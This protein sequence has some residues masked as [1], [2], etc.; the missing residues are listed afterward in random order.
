[1][2]IFNSSNIDLKDDNFE[3]IIFTENTEYNNKCDKIYSDK[4][5]ELEN[6]K[7]EEI[8]EYTNKNDKIEYFSNSIGCPI[9]YG[10][11]LLIYNNNDTKVLSKSDGELSWG[12][13]LKY[14]KYYQFTP[15]NLNNISK[16]IKYGDNIEIEEHK[17]ISSIVSSSYYLYNSGSNEL[18][19]WNTNINAS[20]SSNLKLPY[21]FTVMACVYQTQR[22]RDWVRVIGKGNSRNRNYGI[23]IRSDG[24]TLAQI[25]GPRGGSVWPGPV[26]PLNKWT[27]LAITFKRNNKLKF[28]FNG[29]L[30]R[31]VNTS[32]TPR[33]DNE[34]LTLG[35][36]TFHTKLYGK[37]K[38]AIV[39]NK[40]ISDDKIREFNKAS[41]ISS[42]IA[43]SII[44]R[45][46]REYS[47]YN[48]NMSVSSSSKLKLRERFTVMAWVYQTQRSRDWVRVI[49]KG[50]HR[51]RNYGIWI[52]PNG[53]SL[54]QIYGISNP[55]I[56]AGPVVPLNTW[57]HLATTFRKDGQHKFYF[58]GKL[59]RSSN[60][61][62]TPRTDNE[63][64]KLGGANFHGKFYGKI[65][66][67]FV[68][69][70]AL[71]ENQIQIFSR[72]P[73]DKLES[74]VEDMKIMPGSGNY[75]SKGHEVNYGENIVIETKKKNI[76]AVPKKPIGQRCSIKIPKMIESNDY[77][78]KQIKVRCDDK[79]EMYLD[80]NTYRGSGW[81][82]VFT[83]N[84]PPI[85][86]KEGFI[87]GIKGYN[88]GGPGGILAQIEL[89]NGSLIVTDGSWMA[90]ENIS[91]NF[92]REV[93]EKQTSTFPISEWRTPNVIGLNQ[94][95]KKIFDGRRVSSW[96]R[97]YTDSN[98]SRYAKW[99]WAGGCTRTNV[100]AYVAKKIG[101]PPN[102]GKC[103]HNLTYGQAVCYLERY[104]DIKQ[105]AINA[106]SNKYRY[107]LNTTKASWNDHQNEAIRR[108]GN[109]ACF[110]SKEEEKYAI[111]N[112][113]HKVNS[114]WGYWI[115]AIRIGNN[116]HDRSSRTWKWVDGRPWRYTNFWPNYEP[117]NYRENRLHVWK[118]RANGL[119]GTWNDLSS[120]HGL[121]GLYQFKIPEDVSM[122]KLVEYAKSHWKIWGCRENRVYDCLKPPSTVGEFNYKGCYLDDYN[123]RVIPNYRGEVNS[124]QECKKK[125]EDNRERIF[126]MSDYGKCYTGND[127]EKATKNG[128]GENCPIVGGNGK[129]QVFYRTK[130]YNPIIKDL[131]NK[132]F[133]KLNEN[134]TNQLPIDPSLSNSNFNDHFE[135]N[136]GLK[137]RN[138]FVLIIILILIIILMYYYMK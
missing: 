81:N 45:Q 78:I 108:G 31:E 135:N 70:K 112:Y 29:Q 59:F 75:K 127:L 90:S 47:F 95:G 23:W 33:T 53:H 16:P 100:P 85:K 88:Y 114:G 92:M 131:S 41:G 73:N 77:S 122:D 125:A 105:A 32:G 37:I 80:G 126:G 66:N 117:N 48:H 54:S 57:T 4:K 86:S 40:F 20:Y 72:S 91:N 97:G 119:N 98:F 1:M 51:N 113:L 115:G 110:S 49:G 18:S 13:K 101:N 67:A 82:R 69:D 34:P 60:T 137:K 8:E 19:F 96:D 61:N 44:Y 134:F 121:A 55:N 12:K 104:P 52:H 39:L 64:L 56:W 136:L 109:L 99:I 26:I 89:N 138:N 50:N 94:L 83:F 65:I 35:G 74:F 24:Y 22:S 21:E 111:D 79:F 14:P 17:N 46:P 128:E 7:D 123:S 124:L 132:N 107:E 130:P 15:S 11:R 3:S 71:S 129:F 102:L 10:D 9:V 2:D 38:D 116:S 103:S 84:N 5:L 118:N 106:N 93:F 58:N 28:Y 43:G 133:T 36:A 25:Y 6:F 120:G 62:G 76:D 27:H 63:A 68:L 87:I 30:I 42:N